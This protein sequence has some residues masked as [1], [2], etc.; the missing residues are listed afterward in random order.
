MSTEYIAGA[1]CA[2][3]GEYLFAMDA[4]E[5]QKVLRANKLT[6]EV[7]KSV[8]R[9]DYASPWYQRDGTCLVLVSQ[10]QSSP[11]LAV[12]HVLNTDML[13]VSSFVADCSDVPHTSASCFQTDQSYCAIAGD[14]IYCFLGWR[15]S[16]DP[17]G[18]Y[19]TFRVYE[20]NGSYVDYSGPIFNGP[21]GSLPNT[22]PTYLAI[23]AVA[24]GDGSIAAAAYWAAFQKYIGYCGGDFISHHYSEPPFTAIESNPRRGSTADFV[25]VTVASHQYLAAPWIF[26][27]AGVENNGIYWAF[28]YNSYNNPAS[29]SGEEWSGPIPNDSDFFILKYDVNTMGL[30]GWV[31]SKD[32]HA[33]TMNNTGCAVTDGTY[34][35]GVDGSTPYQIKLEDG[36]AKTLWRKVGQSNAIWFQEG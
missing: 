30:L 4:W 9:T 20:L 34:A 7:T 17:V 21:Y 22:W 36:S 35:W 28:M 2:I 29:F 16:T 3:V 19:A 6:M 5:T 23:V 33:L 25:T 18:Y 24:Q 1:Y 31:Q 13:E 26:P 12:F 32:Y 10:Q 14:K 8:T 11:W 15:Y 27:S